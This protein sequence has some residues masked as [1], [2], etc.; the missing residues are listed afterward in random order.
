[1]DEEMEAV[2]VVEAEFVSIGMVSL[3]KFREWVLGF[4]EESFNAWSMIGEEHDK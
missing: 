2:V 4:E 1:M 3:R